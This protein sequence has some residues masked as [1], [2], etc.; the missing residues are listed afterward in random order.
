MSSEGY[1][2]FAVE[3][4]LVSG[5]ISLGCVCFR[6]LGLRMAPMNLGL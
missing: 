6:V 1:S 2:F 5:I 3:A 4:V